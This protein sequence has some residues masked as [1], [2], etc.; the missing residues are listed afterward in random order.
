MEKFISAYELAIIFKGIESDEGYSKLADIVMKIQQ[1]YG[2][3]PELE[4]YGWWPLQDEEEEYINEEDGTREV[5]VYYAYDY[6]QELPTRVAVRLIKKWYPDGRFFYHLNEEGAK[7][8]EDLRKRH[9]KKY[10]WRTVG[11]E[12]AKRKRFLSKMGI[13]EVV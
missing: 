3:I 10:R 1:T 2:N 12:V 4:G 13:E 5:N 9:G 7:I 8:L 6:Y 11:K